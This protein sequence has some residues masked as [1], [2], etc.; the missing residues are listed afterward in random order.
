MAASRFDQAR[1]V[2][3]TS[4]ARIGSTSMG[5]VTGGRG[6]GSAAADPLPALRILNIR[7]MFRNPPKDFRLHEP[8]VQLDGRWPGHENRRKPQKLWQVARS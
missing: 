2:G 5:R 8:E 3:Q 4:P 6:M 1:R 7:A